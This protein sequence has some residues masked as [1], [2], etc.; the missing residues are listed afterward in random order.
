MHRGDKV[1][2]V[3]PERELSPEESEGDYR[4]GFAQPNISTSTI[5]DFFTYLRVNFGLFLRRKGKKV[6]HSLSNLTLALS[7]AAP[8]LPE[9]K[10]RA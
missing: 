9:P 5:Y 7:A 2:C 6:L 4:V 1:G 3:G 10:A 8:F